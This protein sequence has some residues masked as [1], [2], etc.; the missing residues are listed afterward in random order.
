MTPR[1]L[2]P[3][4]LLFA[5]LLLFRTPYEAS[6]LPWQ[7]DEPFY[8]TAARNFGRDGNHVVR[9]FGREHPPIYPPAFSCLLLAP[10]YRA[11]PQEIGIGVYAVFVAA[12]GAVALA[13][14][15]GG[16]LAG[17]FGAVGAVMGL[18][19]L[20]DFRRMAANIMSDVPSVCALL[21]CC[22]VS[23][24]LGAG[25]PWTRCLGSG[26]VFAVAATVRVLNV[27]V[28]GPALLVGWRLW[29]AREQSAARVAALVGPVLGVL[30]AGAAYNARTFG[31]PLRNGYQYWAPFPHGVAMN[32]GAEWVLRNVGWLLVYGFPAVA[33]LGVT[34]LV[35]LRVLRAGESRA[36]DRFSMFLAMVPGLHSAVLMFYSRSDMRLHLG[37][38]AFLAVVGGAGV[39]A[40]VGRLAGGRVTLAAIGL[41]CAIGWA[42]DARSMRVPEVPTRRLHLERVRAVLPADAAL[43]VTANPLIVDAFVIEGTNRIAVPLDRRVELMDRPIAPRPLAATAGLSWADLPGAYSAVIAAGAEWSVADTATGRPEI[44]ER[45]LAEGRSVWLEAAERAADDPSLELLRRRFRLVQA[46][47]G[48]FRL[49]P[50][51]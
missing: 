25:A 34:G 15:V 50:V 4:C 40:L 24:E 2:L 28:V 29:S 32:F 37:F 45:W 42:A 8:V 6:Q 5:A 7:F 19:W 17:P 48:V 46:V 30:G 18:L 9:M 1:L 16:R 20:A 31:S 43:V 36:L 33:L 11:F 47:P 10:L 26:L 39:G 44:L 21:A 35:L 22:V 3:L 12:L 23:M 13:F 27:V 51:R 41:V 49:G 14:R 38:L